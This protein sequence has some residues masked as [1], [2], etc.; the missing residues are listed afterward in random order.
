MVHLY[1]SLA[2]HMN[3]CSDLVFWVLTHFS[4]N[5]S[6][7]IF[8]SKFSLDICIYISGRQIPVGHQNLDLFQPNMEGRCLTPR[9]TG[10]IQTL[11]DFLKR[12]VPV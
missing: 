11:K 1:F 9:G 2:L 5:F 8:Y 12:S 10:G 6:F 7:T 3:A 4:L